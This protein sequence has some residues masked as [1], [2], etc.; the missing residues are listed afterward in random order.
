MFLVGVHVRLLG[1]MMWVFRGGS[2]AT[3]ASP[4]CYEIHIPVAGNA[5]GEETNDG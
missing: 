5:V 1:G 2:A 3:E 4:F